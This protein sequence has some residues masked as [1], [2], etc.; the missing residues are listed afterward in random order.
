LAWTDR[1]GKPMGLFGP[2]GS[3]NRFRLA[4]D[5][6][7]IVFDVSNQD[8][9]VLDAIRGVTS[10]L[11]SD[12]AFDN[13]PLW[14]PDGL[15]ILWSSNRSG[16][17]HVYTKSAN[18]TGQEELLI[19]MGT[20]T[21]GAVDWSK[22]GR[23]ILYQMPDSKTG[24]DLWIAP[25]FPERAEGDRKPFPY[26]Q[27]QFDE[28][29]GRFSPDG[30]WVAYV[31]N[32]SGRDE[33]YVQSFPITGAKFQISSGGGSEPQWRS[34][35]TELFYLAADGNLMAAPVKLGRSA[36][37]SFQAGLPRPLMAVPF[38]ANGTSFQRTYAVS[39]D[40]QRFLIPSSTS[41]G[42]VPPLTVVLSWQAR[43]KK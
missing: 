16:G 12:P 11:T 43:L 31:S 17:Y 32:E 34:D 36:S 9:W 1:T 7:R 14:S 22:D 27:S 42:N 33:V 21:G 5:E 6:K 19:K 29:D 4:P 38:V 2:P 23:Y 26:L 20:G 8:V 28:Q 3:Y 41:T 39:N 15:H 35:G 40:G 24:Q 10:R 37:E 30:K 18:G 13:V 25:Q